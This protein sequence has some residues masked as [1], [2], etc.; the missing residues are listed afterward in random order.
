[1]RSSRPGNFILLKAFLCI[2][3]A[4]S[5]ADLSRS[6]F[7]CGCSPNLFLPGSL[8]LRSLP[9]H[10]DVSPV[11]VCSIPFGTWVSIH[12]LVCLP[13]NIFNVL[14]TVDVLCRRSVMPDNKK[15]GRKFR[16]VRPQF[17]ETIT[18]PI[19]S[20]RDNHL[21]IPAH[22]RYTERLGNCISFWNRQQFLIISYN[23]ITLF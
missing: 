12:S 18:A 13:F 20:V 10:P 19:S 17:V 1:M 16:T 15:Y 3:R 4:F 22:L 9:S 14:L 6:G 21:K 8:I 11:L 23:E 7:T 2:C 5:R